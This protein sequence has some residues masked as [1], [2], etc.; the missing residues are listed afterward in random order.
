LFDYPGANEIVANTM[1]CPKTT[2]LIKKHIPAHGTA[3]F[4][5][6]AADT[7]ITPHTGYQGNCLRMH[8]GLEIP[9]GDCGLRVND[10]IYHWYPGRAFIF[11][12]HQQHDAWNS[13]ESDRVILIVDF[14]PEPRLINL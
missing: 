11:D 12:D 8:L 13:T 7:I 10:D 14:I 5:R 1:L 3:G 6:L 4:S 2:E 9:I